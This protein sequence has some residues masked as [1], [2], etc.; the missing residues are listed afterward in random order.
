VRQDRVLPTLVVLFV[1]SYR[2]SVS[3]NTASLARS[4]ET[5][6]PVNCF[7]SLYALTMKKKQIVAF[8]SA[9]TLTQLLMGLYMVGI[10]SRKHGA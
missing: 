8:F 3:D 6:P 7:N 10:A 4:G 2:T 9:I 5:V 1:H